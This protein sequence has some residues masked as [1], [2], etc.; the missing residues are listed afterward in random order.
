MLAIAP[1]HFLDDDGLTTAAIDATHRRKRKSQKALKRNELETAPGELIVSG[2]RLMAARTNRR[3]TFARTH[4]D[5]DAL[6]IG[7]ETGLLLNE[8]RKVVATV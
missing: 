8:S 2:G 1:G 5:F 7:T 3:R 4:G 6:V